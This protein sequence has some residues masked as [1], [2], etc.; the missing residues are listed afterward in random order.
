MFLELY[1]A[2]GDPAFRKGL[3]NLYLM[4]SEDVAEWYR[5]NECGGIDAGVCHLKEAFSTGMSPEHTAIASEIIN[6]RY[7]GSS[8]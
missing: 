4:S 8:P 5:L 1:D 2:L 6:R 7:F 3:R